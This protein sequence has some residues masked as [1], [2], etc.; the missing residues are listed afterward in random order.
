MNKFI[1]PF[2]LLI[3]SIIILTNWTIPGFIQKY[4]ILKELTPFEITINNWIIGGIIGIILLYLAP[5]INNKFK[6][7]DKTYFNYNVK[8]NINYYYLFIA[9]LLFGILSTLSYYYLLKIANISKITAY[10]NPINIILIL[11]ISK[12]CFN[13]QIS[14]G[15]CFG[16]FLIIIGLFIMY[17]YEK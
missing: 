14:H 5:P 16:I 2:S 3:P 15:S 17:Y 9:L 1:I 6:F 10:L 7:F 4:Y 8:K 12:F 11:L 13:E